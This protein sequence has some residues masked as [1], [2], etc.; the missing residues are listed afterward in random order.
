[1]N[2]SCQCV[3]IMLMV[4]KRIYEQADTIT[5][6]KEKLSQYEERFKVLDYQGKQWEEVRGVVVRLAHN[7]T[8]FHPE[9]V[10]KDDFVTAN[11]K[12]MKD[13]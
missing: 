7:E 6:L 12:D 3:E 4:Q 1:M 9:V 13:E 10:T 11:L 8:V 2:C 5:L